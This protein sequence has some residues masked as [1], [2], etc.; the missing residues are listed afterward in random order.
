MSVEG[1]GPRGRAVAVHGLD[2][3]GH[4]DLL[5]EPSVTCPPAL[6][7]E[8]CLRQTCCPPGPVPQPPGASD[9]G[10]WPSPQTAA[11][12]SLSEDTKCH[13]GPFQ[14]PAR[15]PGEAPTSQD[16]GGI[17]VEKNPVGPSA[18]DSSGQGKCHGSSG[19]GERW[20]SCGPIQLGE[21]ADFRAALGSECF[22]VQEAPLVL[23]WRRSQ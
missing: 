20:M 19:A 21:G 4:P 22:R 7:S 11:M 9:G 23:Q 8:G 6:G 15:M 2:H 1:S 18:S 17:G 14:R 13:A 5:R 12:G 3:E 10:G 16:A